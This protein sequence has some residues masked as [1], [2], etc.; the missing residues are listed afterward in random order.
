M[1]AEGAPGVPWPGR[2]D[3][4][5]TKLQQGDHSTFPLLRHATLSS[6]VLEAG[7]ML[8]M[9][10]GWFHEVSSVGQHCALNYWFHPPRLYPS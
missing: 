6:C 7:E 1:E 9:P 8:Y 5:L 4:E 2:L 3:A 10:A